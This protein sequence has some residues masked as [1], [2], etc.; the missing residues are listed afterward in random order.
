MAK[1]LLL[2]TDTAFCEALCGKLVREGYSTLIAHDGLRGLELARMAQPDLIILETQLPQLDGFAVCRILRFESNVPI[3][4]L[5]AIQDAA[6]RVRGLALG[7]DDYVIKPFL[8]DELLVRV[9]A[10][11]RRSA[12]PLRQARRELLSVENLLLDT[13]NRCVLHA[14]EELRLA[15]KEF[16]LLACLMHNAQIPAALPR[17]GAAGDPSLRLAAAGLAAAAAGELPRRCGRCS[18]A[19]AVDTS[20]PQGS[21][22]DG[23]I[24]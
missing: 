13:A 4:M 22:N 10:L 3:L 1:I 18:D 5:T 15:Q 23:T 20:P 8:P 16:D 21:H 6:D 11:L 2:D 9:R 19:Q 14:G 12:R 17:T 24:E 7:A